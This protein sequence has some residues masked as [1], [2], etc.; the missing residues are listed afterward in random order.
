MFKKQNARKGIKTLTGVTLNDRSTSL[1]NKM[2]ERALRHSINKIGNVRIRNLSLKNK[3]P[4]RA[5]RPGAVVIAPVPA[6]RY[7]FKKQNAR[8]GIKTRQT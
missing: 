4:E 8:K 7:T 2:P 5:L 3:M 1:K 6:G